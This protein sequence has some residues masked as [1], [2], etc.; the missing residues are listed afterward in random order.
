MN[1]IADYWLFFFKLR[2]GR[3]RRKLFVLELKKKSIFFLLFS[4]FAELNGI[5]G[6]Y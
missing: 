5:L 2:Q 6:V 3:L 4:T 1:G